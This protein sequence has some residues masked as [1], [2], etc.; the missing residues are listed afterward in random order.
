MH[1]DRADTAYLGLKLYLYLV[2]QA[3]RLGN[4]QVR[5]GQAVKC[6]IVAIG[7]GSD[8]ESVAATQ[9]RDLFCYGSDLRPQLFFLL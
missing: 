5:I 1:K 3:M 8:M 9:S 4:G 7:A 2:G 6:N